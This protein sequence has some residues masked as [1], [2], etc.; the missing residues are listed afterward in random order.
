M[1]IHIYI[2]IFLYIC[3]YICICIYIRI[4]IYICIFVPVKIYA[5]AYTN[6]CVY[7]CIYI[8]IYVHT[9]TCM[10]AYTYMH[11]YIHI[12]TYIQIYM[13]THE[14]VWMYIHKYTR[15]RTHNHVGPKNPITQPHT[16]RYSSASNIYNTGSKKNPISRDPRNNYPHTLGYTRTLMCGFIGLFSGHTRVGR[17]NAKTWVSRVRSQQRLNLWVTS[18]RYVSHGLRYVS[19]GLSI[20]ESQTIYES[21]ASDMWVMVTDIWVMV[22][23]ICESWPIYVW[24]ANHLWVTI[25]WSF[26]HTNVSHETVYVSHELYKPLV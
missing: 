13:Y 4:C 2:H 15:P 19:H 14:S 16:Q 24:V 23:D 17:V 5:H 22:S 18:H 7:V 11:T 20:F 10:H 8:C 12:C 1:Y 9:Y 21:R 25:F 6:I 3:M 26:H